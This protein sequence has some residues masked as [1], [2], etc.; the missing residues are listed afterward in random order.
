MD[1]KIEKTKSFILYFALTVVGIYFFFLAIVEAKSFF[2]PL[3]TGL[4]LAMLV[5][6]VAKKLESWGV[7]RGWAALFSDLLLIGFTVLLFWVIGLQIEKIQ[8]DWPQLKK[9]LV[10]QAKVV[11]EK[12]DQFSWLKGQ[13]G[14]SFEEEI[15]QVTASPLQPSSQQVAGTSVQND[16]IPSTTPVQGKNEKVTANNQNT[17]DNGRTSISKSSILSVL[18]S[19]FGLLGTM[20]LIFIYIFF[21]LLY[22]D[23]F[24]KSLYRFS[25]N[26]KNEKT[27]SIILHSGM[28]AQQYLWGKFILIIF[29]AV[30]YSIG[31]TISGVKYAIFISVIAAVFSLLP[32]IG[33]VIGFIFAAIMA[34]LASGAG[35]GP[36]IGVAITFS[37][38]QFVESYILEPY[39]V[40]HKVDMNPVMT[41][42][43]VVFGEFIWGVPGMVLAIPV[44]GIVKVICDRIEVLQPVGYAIGEEG[45]EGGDNIF[46]KFGKWVKSKFH[47]NE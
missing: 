43:A 33:N 22:R 17:A 34:L 4:L 41:I 26:E 11:D 1:N 31:L 27:K 30:L 2:V 44:L 39:I 5:V 40:G 6:P 19:F 7:T 10:R 12:L 47:K 42:I 23:K 35:L 24:K 46:T 15:K 36:L 18:K 3:V 37:I 29:L 20:L 16:S 14:I 45:I 28:V 32:Y 8:E 38:T 13:R 21:F 25:P 9:E